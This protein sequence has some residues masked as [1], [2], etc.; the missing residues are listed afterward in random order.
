M[1]DRIDEFGTFVDLLPYQSTF[2]TAE[3]D[4]YLNILLTSTATGQIQIVV[5]DSTES[6]NTFNRQHNFFVSVSEESNRGAWLF[7]KKEQD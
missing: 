3:T 6:S 5:S 7:I 1:S 4:G 2:Y